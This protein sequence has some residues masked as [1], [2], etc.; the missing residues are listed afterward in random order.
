MEKQP[1]YSRLTIGLSLITLLLCLDTG[2][3]QT[4][5]EHN[6]AGLS[7]YSEK[8]FKEA[9][10]SFDKAL[11]LDPDNST[12]RGNLVIAYHGYAMQQSEQGAIEQAIE[13]ERHAFALAETN[14][15]I[16]TQLALLYNNY[17]SEAARTGDV[18]RARTLLAEAISLQPDNRLFVTNMCTL[19]MQEARS[20]RKKGDD[21]NCTR[22]LNEA[23][24]LNPDSFPVH[25][26]LGE[27]YYSKNDYAGSIRSFEHAFVLNPF[28][29]N[30]AERLLQIRKESSVEKE[31]G[32]NERS[33]FIIR[34]ENGVNEN[35][36]WN[37]SGILD[38]AYRDIGQKLECWPKSPMTVIIYSKEQFT[39]VTSAPDW[40]IGRFDGKLRICA[41]DL[42]FEKE[43]LKSVVRHEYTH[44][45]VFDLYGVKIP[46]WINEGLAQYAA[47]DSAL[48]ANDRGLLQSIGE[49]NL[50]PPW[51]LN[52]N[53]NSTNQMDVAQAYLESQIFVKYLFDRYG[54]AVSRQFIAES[55]KGTALGDIT[56]SMFNRTPEQLYNEWMI[57]FKKQIAVDAAKVP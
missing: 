4:A 20:L 35:L 26:E 25:A 36:S 54:N 17:G 21:I 33:R 49:H 31:F 34:Y 8:R 57:E 5:E 1:R 46:L 47:T 30:V 13:T 18:A 41:S 29:T 32:K 48:T 24:A 39:A 55:A 7:Q 22:L 27:Y 38:D 53:F 3:A 6:D 9:I 11:Q 42:I 40:T 10:G 43:T 37:I 16:R 52:G 50:V 51:N 56:G 44:A 45:L 23:V 14:Q 28:A 15:I 2:L 12:V 19:L